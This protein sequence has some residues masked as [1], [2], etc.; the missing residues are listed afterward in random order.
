MSEI[1]RPQG[2]FTTSRNIGRVFDLQVENLLHSLE[3]VFKCI[4]LK[5]MRDTMGHDTESRYA[6]KAQYE[7][8]PV[9]FVGTKEAQ[10]FLSVPFIYQYALKCT[11]MSRDFLCLDR[12]HG[13]ANYD[14]NCNA[15]FPL[16]LINVRTETTHSPS[17]GSVSVVINQHGTSVSSAGTSFLRDY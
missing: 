17:F 7:L 5:R 9:S 4:V 6:F 15:L 1:F 12:R 3:T 16:S 11:S 2:V 8:L 14:F 13:A 10:M